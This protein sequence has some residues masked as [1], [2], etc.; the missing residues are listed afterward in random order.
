MKKSQ[1]G[2]KKSQ[3]IDAAQAMGSEK[4][5]SEEALLAA[6]VESFRVTFSK[7]I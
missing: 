4:G 5:V 6:L 3:F 1:T 7:K 2:F